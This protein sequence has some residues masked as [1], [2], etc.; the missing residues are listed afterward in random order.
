[1]T[2]ETTVRSA[3]TLWQ[4]VVKPV[5]ARNIDDQLLARVGFLFECRVVDAQ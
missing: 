3:S 1:L 5:S 2:P 4:C